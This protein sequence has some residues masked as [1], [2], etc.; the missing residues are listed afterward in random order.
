MAERNVGTSPRKKQKSMQKY[1]K[2]Y[3]KEFPVFTTS[4]KGDTFA[5]CTLCC[6]HL[7]VAHGGRDDLKK[8]TRSVKHLDLTRQQG[9]NLKLDTFFVSDKDGD[10]VIKA[11]VL[12]T[13]F[14][15][16][17]N[18][19][20]AAADHAAPLFRQMFHDSDVAKKYGSG[21]T[22][23][24]AIIIDM[25]R[26]NSRYIANFLC[27]TAFAIAMDGSN[28]TDTK[29]YPVVV[30]YYNSDLGEV[31]CHLL[32]LPNLVGNS[33]GE[34]IAGLLNETMERFSIPWKNCISVSCDNAAV[35]I[36]ANKGVTK[37]LKDYQPEIITVGCPCHLIHL[38]AEK[39]A[40]EFP[41]S[42]EEHIYIYIYIIFLINLPN[43]K[44]N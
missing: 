28:D 8:H 38:A 19:P 12:F 36:G 10:S 35:M 4:S 37:F 7:S 42:V 3:S 11:E 24:T 40:G 20:I 44:K 17:H 25:S 2:E 5:F 29:L 21:R 26:Q 30:R 34:N 1:R 27:H 15:I 23:T 18:I 9:K 39:A 32:A 13:Q 31:V 14:L 16:E 33:T 6:V 41:V 43:V 22:K